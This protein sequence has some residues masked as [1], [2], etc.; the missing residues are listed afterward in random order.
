MKLA[1]LLALA[2]TAALLAFAPG[3]VTQSAHASYR[4]WCGRV[5]ASA[6]GTTYRYRLY[7]HNMGCAT[8]T[9]MLRRYIST[10]HHPTGY[11]CAANVLLCWSAEA[12][13]PAAAR[14]WFRGYPG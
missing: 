14:R 4:G 3:A 7:V 10:G 9:R 12:A 8:A 6:A 2:C 13:R 11:T 1:L 5:T